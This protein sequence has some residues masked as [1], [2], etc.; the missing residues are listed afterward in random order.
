MGLKA[1][2]ERVKHRLLMFTR[3]V[4]DNS[5]GGVLIISCKRCC[6]SLLSCR[7]THIPR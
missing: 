4:F 3:H 6:T 7:M 5:I 1:N 2:E